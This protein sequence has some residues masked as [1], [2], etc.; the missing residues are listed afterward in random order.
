[1]LSDTEHT[2]TSSASDTNGK[3]VLS[4]HRWFV[5]ITGQCKISVLKN[6]QRMH[7]ESFYLSVLSISK[8]PITILSKCI[9]RVAGFY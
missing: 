4:L 5:F 3:T 2:Q 7:L 8:V 6:S 1:M 9:N